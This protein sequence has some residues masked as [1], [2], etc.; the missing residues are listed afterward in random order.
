[1]PR[2]KRVDDAPEDVADPSAVPEPEKLDEAPPGGRFR[3]G[4]RL[5]DAEGQP[6][7]G[8]E[9]EPGESEDE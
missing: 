2:R 6:I 9:D 3:V 8:S 7:D 5:V 1:M 4:G